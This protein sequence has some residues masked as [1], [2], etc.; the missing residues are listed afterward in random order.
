MHSGLGPFIHYGFHWAL[1]QGFWFSLSRPG[2]V[3]CLQI[4]MLLLHIHDGLLNLVVLADKTHPTRLQLTQ[5]ISN[6]SLLV[7]SAPVHFLDCFLHFCQ[8][9]LYPVEHVLEDLIVLFPTLCAIVEHQVKVHDPSPLVLQ[10]GTTV[11]NAFCPCLDIGHLAGRWG[12]QLVSLHTE[13]V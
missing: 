12:G 10:L 1:E 5:F 8:L 13:R 2:L 11:L 3:L 7:L 9:S 4:T 6:L